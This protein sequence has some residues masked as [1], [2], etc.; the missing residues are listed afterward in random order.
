MLDQITSK[1]PQISNNFQ[2]PQQFSGQRSETMFPPPQLRTASYT[3]VMC[4]KH[5]IEHL[6]AHHDAQKGHLIE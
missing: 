3:Y 2:T 4:E 1:D 5:R 6:L